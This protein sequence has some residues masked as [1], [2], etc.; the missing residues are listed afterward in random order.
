M[1]II[2]RKLLY[3]FILVLF[4]THLCNIHA[5]LQIGGAAA[6][7]NINV[8]RLSHIAPISTGSVHTWT[9]DKRKWAHDESKRAQYTEDL[10]DELFLTAANHQL[11]PN[12]RF[13]RCN[14]K[15]AIDSDNGFDG[16]YILL[17][18]DDNI[19]KLSNS[20]NL[21]KGS[22]R[23]AVIPVIILTE[24]KYKSNGVLQL[25]AGINGAAQMSEA[26]IRYVAHNLIKNG[27][28]EGLYPITVNE[29]TEPNHH[30]C[31]STRAQVSF[32]LDKIAKEN[33]IIQG[34]F[35]LA[36]L[37]D[38]NGNFSVYILSN[39]D[40]MRERT[41]NLLNDIPLLSCKLR[42]QTKKQQCSIM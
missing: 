9:I 38:G 37:L 13:V 40:D 6:D 42:D 20:G 2:I 32:F 7:T 34:I 39:N 10:T 28:Q 35:R 19:A 8:N 5:S 21:V 16:F 25:G 11:Q 27:M 18:A 26:W 31:E 15:Y 33:R 23:D 41:Q 24:S 17:D 36:T 22:N 30:Y 3:I 14:G 4:F 1:Q 29:H 12:F